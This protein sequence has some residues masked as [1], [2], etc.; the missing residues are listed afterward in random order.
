MP[1]L[2]L[3]LLGYFQAALDDRPITSFES[4]KVRALL[5]YLAVEADRP[6]SRD[7]LIG[8]LWPDRPEAVARANLRQALANLRRA[9]GDRGPEPIFLAVTTDSIQFQHSSQHWIDATALRTLLAECNAHTHE[10]LELCHAC[11][12]RLQQAVALYRAEF[13]AQFLQSGSEAFEEWAMLKRTRLH[14]AALEAMHTLT[15]YHLQRADCAQA[16]HYALRQLELDPW[17]EEAHRQ[18]MQALAL[19]GQRSAALVQYKMCR[20]ILSD[21]LGAE[22]EHETTMLYDRI[23]EGT[24]GARTLLLL[25]IPPLG[26]SR[27]GASRLIDVV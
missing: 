14:R 15:A 11:A 2:A 16:Q 18:M 7:E 13:L 20:R 19:A 4:N 23:K 24:L 27:R 25:H 12:Q 17:R 8:L 10:R 1:T 5:A 21:E 3:S 22:P 26:Q 6:H 9:I